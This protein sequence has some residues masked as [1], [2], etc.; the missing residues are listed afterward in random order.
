MRRTSA[1]TPIVN[2]LLAPTL[3]SRR[4]PDAVFAAL[5]D[6]ASAGVGDPPVPLDDAD[7]AS[8]RRLLRSAAGADL[9]AL[10]WFLFRADVESRMANL[11]RVAARHAAFPEIGR[12]AIEAPIV[13]VGL[14]RTG[15]TITHKVIAQ[16]SGH[17]APAL[18]E[19][20][21][22]DLELPEAERRK[23]V[24]GI[25]AGL[26]V[27]SG[28][29]PSMRVIHPQS[30][31]GPDEDPFALPHGHQHAARAAMPD[32]EAWCYERDYTRD[33]DHLK[34]VYQVLQ[35]GR[36]PARWVLK[37][38]T[39][40]AQLDQV[41]RVFPN[42][43]IVW[44]HRFPITVIGSICSLVESARRLHQRRVDLH[45]IGRMCLEQLSWMV[46]RAR[47]AR[48]SIPRDR[49]IDVPYHAIAAT[50]E[51]GIPLLYERLGA[52]WTD[53]DAANLAATMARPIT[54]A[55]EYELGRY[56]LTPGMVEDAFGDYS[57]AEA[58]ME[59]R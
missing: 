1:L 53:R 4:D 55:H 43:T 28:L 29:V 15:T 33:Y 52:A 3:R 27:V 9:S 38:P 6:R 59:F 10:G 45:G 31:S 26:K 37:S 50:P 7:L 16:S 30:A 12:E 47:T 20:M 18:W 8:F 5:F 48:A 49:I 58:G 25:E 46:E 44:L 56:G 42:A 13:I 11:L 39:H 22:T 40:L 54:R 23:V 19:L 14:P 17:R 51:T 35:H 32:Y 57:Q 36:A 34:R 24:R 21:H 41:M 2:A